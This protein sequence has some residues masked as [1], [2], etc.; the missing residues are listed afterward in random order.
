[1]GGG[2]GGGHGEGGGMCGVTMEVVKRET[3][4]V[5]KKE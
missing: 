2:G 1:M 3:R 5:M 4:E